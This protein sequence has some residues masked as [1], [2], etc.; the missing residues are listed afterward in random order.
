MACILTNLGKVIVCREFSKVKSITATKVSSSVVTV[1]AVETK[2]TIP[3]I[4]RF[5]RISK[6]KIVPLPLK[7]LR[8]LKDT[9]KGLRM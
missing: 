9:V 4:S 6:D 5:G 7:Q 8:R 1:S 3:D 2:K